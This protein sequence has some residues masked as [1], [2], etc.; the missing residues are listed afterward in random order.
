MHNRRVIFSFF[1]TRV[2]I[3]AKKKSYCFKDSRSTERASSSHT[4]Q[5]WPMRFSMGDRSR[6][7]RIADEPCRYI[8]YYFICV[9]NK[10]QVRKF[11][12]CIA[13][14]VVSLLSEY[15]YEHEYYYYYYYYS[16]YNMCTLFN[17]WCASRSRHYCFCG[18]EL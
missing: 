4:L 18:R 13:E 10:R 7:C 5:R 6:R 16:T 8:I 15:K 11:S 14:W 9:C 3:M 1:F 2:S 12:F 17:D